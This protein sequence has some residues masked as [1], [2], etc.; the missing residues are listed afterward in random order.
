MK[1]LTY[2][3]QD[4]LN[5]Q[6]MALNFACAIANI[7]NRTLLLRETF[8][9]HQYAMVNAPYNLKVCD[10]IDCPALNCHTTLFCTQLTS[11]C[12]TLHCVLQSSAPSVELP[13]KV[14]LELGLRGRALGRLMRRHKLSSSVPVHSQ[15]EENASRVLAGRRFNALHV[16]SFSQNDYALHRGQTKKNNA[17]HIRFY[18]DSYV[19]TQNCSTLS[20]PAPLC[21]NNLFPDITHPDLKCILSQLVAIRAHRFEGEAFSTVSQFVYRR[22]FP[23]DPNVLCNEVWCWPRH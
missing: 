1:W 10:V 17:G 4:G 15:F 20:V 16:R 12:K 9:P 14:A 3:D 6:L 11:I 5:N 22:R 8:T 2:R 19:M 13:N 21:M 7:T 18:N 23:R